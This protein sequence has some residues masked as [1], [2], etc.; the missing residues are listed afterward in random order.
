MEVTKWLKPSVWLVTYRGRREC[1]GRNASER[2]ASLEKD[3]AQ[4][5]PTAISGKADTIGRIERG[6]TPDRCAGV[7]ATACTQG[8][9]T[10]HGKPQ[11]VISDAQPD[12][13]E[14]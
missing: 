8:K 2:R 7:L 4:A 14:G 1:A 9:R 5:D 11:G 13:R 6:S 10:Q 3:D 12:A